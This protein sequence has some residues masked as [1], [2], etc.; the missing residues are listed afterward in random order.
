MTILVCLVIFT[1]FRNL[2]STDSPV[3]TVSTV[4]SRKAP[5]F[6]LLK[7]KVFFHYAFFNQGR[8]YST[9]QGKNLIDRFVTIKGFLAFDQGIHQRGE[10]KLSYEFE[11]DFKPYSQLVDTTILEEI[12]EHKESMDLVQALGLCPE[13]ANAKDKYFVQSKLQDPPSYSIRLFVFPCS[14]PNAEDCASASEFKGTQLLHTNTR[15]GFDVSNYENPLYTIV[16]FDGYE[17]ID[18]AISKVMFYKIRD[19]EVWDDTHDFLTRV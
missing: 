16:E 9:F 19:N 6:D 17:Q 10:R 2:R 11:L 8:T 5:H 4:Y 18:P 1:S 12:L 14:L 15:K 7:Q 3:A 13:L